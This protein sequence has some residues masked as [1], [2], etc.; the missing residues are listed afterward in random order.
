MSITLR[1]ITPANFKECINLKVGA[2]Q[3]AFVASNLMS[4]AQSKIYPTYNP[5]AV[6]AGDE[7]VGFA[8]FGLDEDDGRY[9]L[10]RIMIDE[11]CQGKGYGRA[12]VLAVIEKLRENPD[13]RAI[14]LSFVPGNTSAETLY[15][16][17]GFEATGEINEG[18]IVM[19][20]DL[21]NNAN[22]KSEIQNRTD[23]SRNF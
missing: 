11:R 21:E 2:A 23:V 18:E 15:K 17:V 16:S 12:A 13:C 9:Y 6:Y 5:A 4:I 7:M 10:G 8:M 22:P 19:R 1:E 14:Y 20:L 3:S